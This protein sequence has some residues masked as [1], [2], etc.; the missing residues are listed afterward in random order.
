MQIPNTPEDLN[1]NITRK[2]LRYLLP[3]LIMI[4][5]PVVWSI[6]LGLTWVGELILFVVSL[7]LVYKIPWYKG[8]NVEHEKIDKNRQK[9]VLWAFA[10]VTTVV[11][12]AA[13]LFELSLQ[14]FLVDILGINPDTAIDSIRSFLGINVK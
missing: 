6:D 10:V 5:L 7:V 8:L 13:P 4:M 9:K 11:L 12:I 14:R 1:F 3:I 2:N